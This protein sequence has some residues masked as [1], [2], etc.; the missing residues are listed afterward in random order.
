MGAPYIYD[1]NHLRVK[2]IPSD[3]STYITKAYWVLKFIT[4]NTRTHAHAHTHT[5]T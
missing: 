1:I 3:S 4:C 2:T 5:H